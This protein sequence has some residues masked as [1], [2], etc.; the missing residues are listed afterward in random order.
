MTLSPT[1]LSS[2]WW[3][4]RISK[5]TRAG[6]VAIGDNHD[7]AHALG[8]PVLGVRFAAVLFGGLMAG[9]GVPTCPSC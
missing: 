2:W 3:R 8:Y 5:R 1:G 4:L 9:I 6:L 7:R